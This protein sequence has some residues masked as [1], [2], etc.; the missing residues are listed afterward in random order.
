MRQWGHVDPELEDIFKKIQ[1]YWAQYLTRRI[2]AMQIYMDQYGL[3]DDDGIYT[4][5]REN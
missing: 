1:D 3:K 4:G 2:E 5:L